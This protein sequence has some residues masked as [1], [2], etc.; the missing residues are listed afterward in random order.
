MIILIHILEHSVKSTYS[1]EDMK[2]VERERTHRY[3]TYCD[4]ISS[5][6]PLRSSRAYSLL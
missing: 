5:V 6:D 2:P 4:A 1:C 3:C